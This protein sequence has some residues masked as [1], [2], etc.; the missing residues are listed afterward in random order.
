MIFVLIQSYYGWNI[1]LIFPVFGAMLGILNTI[2]G[3]Y[4]IERKK[5]GLV[6]SSAIAVVI[7]CLP[8]WYMAFDHLEWS[9]GDIPVIIWRL[10]MPTAI[11]AV[12]LLILS[13][14]QF[15]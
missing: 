2:A 8:V 10:N 3:V 4:A 11:A 13:K 5:W 14:E 6:V 7:I 1:S 12:V 15:E 9:T